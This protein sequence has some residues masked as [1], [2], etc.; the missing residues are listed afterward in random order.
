[1]NAIIKML[2]TKRQTALFSATQTQKV[3]DL[4]RLSLSKPVMVQVK[5]DD[6][7]ATVNTL[8]Q[9][10]VVRDAAQRFQLLYT[11]LKKNTS[12]KVMVFFSSCNSVKFH[13]DL[14]NYVD[15]PCQ[16]LHGQKKQAGRTHVF[17]NFIQSKTGVLLCTDVAAR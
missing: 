11:F 1:M 4:A 13:D 6:S 12:K 9:G 5:S 10:Y 8:Q 15:I 14:L 2:P 3:A 7:V 16:S 17:H